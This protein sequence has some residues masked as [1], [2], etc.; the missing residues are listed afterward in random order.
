MLTKAYWS[1]LVED[2]WTGFLTG[3]GS[4]F[5]GD[6]VNAWTVDWKLALGLGVGTAALMVVKGGALAKVGAEDSPRLK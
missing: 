1:R 3:F 5:V 6:V 2:A 4:A